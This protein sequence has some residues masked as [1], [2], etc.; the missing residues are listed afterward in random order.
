MSLQSLLDANK[1]MT[2]NVTTNQSYLSTTDAALSN[3]S[4]LLSQAQANAL[5]V[6][7]SNATAEQRSAAAQQIDQ[8]IQELMNIGNQQFEGR[9]LFA[10][11]N[12]NV[13]PF[14]T[15]ASGAIQ[16]NGNDQ[17]L[18]SFSDSNQL[19]DTNVTGAEAFGAISSPIA[20]AALNPSLSFDTPLADLRGGAGIS[21]GSIEISDGSGQPSVVDLSSA[22]TIGDVAALISADPP[23]GRTLQ[24][25]LDGHRPEYPT[26]PRRR[27]IQ[28]AF[29]SATSA[30]TPLQ[31][32][33]AFSATAPRAKS[34]GAT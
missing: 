11:S 8:T 16:Y 29:R 1:Q 25:D 26:R 24:V 33:W 6:V 12:V 3:M 23:Q 15:T 9:Y 32:S 7:G 14:T 34:R 18:S 30:P 22:K 27:P 2:T 19:F 17:S 4:N 31:A 28:Y 13:T 21:M 10:G 5:A 20:G